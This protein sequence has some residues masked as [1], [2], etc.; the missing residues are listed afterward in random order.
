M[1]SF[2]VGSEVIRRRLS[3]VGAWRFV[4]VEPAISTRAVDRGREA[5][6]EASGE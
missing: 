4:V 3:E 2:T 5:S 1:V 6:G